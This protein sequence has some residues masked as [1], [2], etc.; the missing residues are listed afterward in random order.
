M[1]LRLVAGACPPRPQQPAERPTDHAAQ[2]GGAGIPEAEE[3]QAVGSCHSDAVEELT[4]LAGQEK[5][6][7]GREQ[8]R[9]GK[10]M[11]VK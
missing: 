7:V 9:P 6:V 1:L 11:C 3:L 4:F 8:L 2:D 10:K 5:W